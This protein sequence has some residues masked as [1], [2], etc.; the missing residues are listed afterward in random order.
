M[1][2]QSCADIFPRRMPR[3]SE[4]STTSPTTVTV[5]CRLF[6]RYAEVAGVEALTLELPAPATAA[7]AV[8]SLRARAPR[9]SLLPEHPMVAVNQQHALPDT[10]L[11]SG[12]ELAVLPPLAGG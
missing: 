5:T 2:H 6:G 12:D 10:A 7:D 3:A 4:R 11:A 9:G 1:P 8:A